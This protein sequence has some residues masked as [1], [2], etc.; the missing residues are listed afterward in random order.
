[1][2]A[3]I[4]L[5]HHL[6]N[7]SLS[8]GL[9]SIV[10]KRSIAGHSGLPAGHP[11][12][13]GSLSRWTKPSG[14]ISE[15]RYR[16][17][18]VDWTT[19]LLCTVVSILYPIYGSVQAIQFGSR[20][21]HVQWI[22]FWAVQA[23]LSMIECVLRTISTFPLYY[24]ELKLVFALWLVSGGGSETLFHALV[25]PHFLI[26]ERDIDIL[27][28]ASS[29]RA[30]GLAKDLAQHVIMALGPSLRPLSFFFFILCPTPPLS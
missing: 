26:Y 11:L 13:N 1:M 20:D 28:V 5:R 7:R 25:H 23:I 2:I 14:A 17:M 30:W 9:R 4:R 16:D 15:F 10:I 27:I 8:R 6:D 21:D 22:I 24:L 19:Q 3:R 18:L 29:T 12:Y